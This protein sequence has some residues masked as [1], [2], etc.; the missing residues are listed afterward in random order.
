MISESLLKY[1]VGIRGPQWWAIHSLV[2]TMR[3]YHIG[4]FFFNIMHSNIHTTQS[5][6]S[7]TCTDTQTNH[8]LEYLGLFFLPAIFMFML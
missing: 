5:H 7:Y 2:H 3:I 8:S 4:C 6:G 1:P